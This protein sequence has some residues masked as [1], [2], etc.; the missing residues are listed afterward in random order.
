M[1]N[2]LHLRDAE[3][4][5]FLEVEGKIRKKEGDK[6]APEGTLTGFLRIMPCAYGKVGWVVPMAQS[7]ALPNR[8][9]FLP[10]EQ[11]LISINLF[12]SLSLF[13]PAEQIKGER[14]ELEKMILAQ[15]SRILQYPMA[16]DAWWSHLAQGGRNTRLSSCYDG[17]NQ[18]ADNSAGTGMGAQPSKT[19]P[20]SRLPTPGPCQNSSPEGITDLKNVLQTGAQACKS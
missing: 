2:I 15:S 19:C 8:P 7:P 10:N 20:N 6:T 11:R 1:K 4:W 16:R 12:V 5:G 17:A 14:E 18:E 9:F 13:S 3:A